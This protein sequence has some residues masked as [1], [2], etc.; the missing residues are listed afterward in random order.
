MHIYIFRKHCKFCSADVCMYLINYAF[1]TSFKFSS[2]VESPFSVLFSTTFSSRRSRLSFL[3]PLPFPT[4]GMLCTTRLCRRSP[5]LEQKHLSHVG[6]FRC[7]PTWS[8][9]ACALCENSIAF[10]TSSPQMGHDDALCGVWAW[11]SSLAWVVNF[12]GQR[13]QGNLSFFL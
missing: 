11:A 10:V 1:S 7:A 8:G 4:P 9:W 12:L 5:P 2:T 6:H 13:V 3:T